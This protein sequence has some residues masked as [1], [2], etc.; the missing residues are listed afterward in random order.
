MKS[1]ILII[2]L[3]IFLIFSLKAQNF[4]N[5]FLGYDFKLYK[6]TFFKLN[7]KASGRFEHTFYGDLRHLQSRFDENILYPD[8]KY[9][10]VTVKDSLSNR[11]FIVENII[12]NTGAEFKGSGYID[13][14]IF[15]LIDTLTK[16]KI[17][18]RYDP[19]YDF[20][21]PFLTSSIKFDE[22][23]LCS[24]LE[25]TVDDFTDEIQ[26]TSPLSSNLKTSSVIIDKH[27][28]KSDIMY[29]LNLRTHGSTVVVDGTGAII[30][31]SDGTK[32]S[33]SVKVNVKAD[34]DGYEYYV[35]FPLT[36]S[37]L[38]LLSTATI[39]KFRLYIFDEAVNPIEADKF[40]IYV[41]CIIK[42]I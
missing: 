20:N 12:D 36:Q 30:L 34:K 17:Y 22:A 39:K 14:P 35:Y 2:S 5:T 37:D 7:P 24:R 6:G 31:F 16:Q 8:T 13:D 1:I 21:F 9:N 18:F 15:T 25:K 42:A 29:F 26:F 23:V 3:Y 40:K 19:R 41:N 11:I 33:K 10:F 27:I 32:L 4:D 28:R 38:T